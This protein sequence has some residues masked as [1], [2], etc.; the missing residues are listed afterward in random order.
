MVKATRDFETRFTRFHDETIEVNGRFGPINK[1]VTFLWKPGGQRRYQKQQSSYRSKTRRFRAPNPYGLDIIDGSI[2]A[3]GAVDGG[4][5]SN[6]LLPDVVNT[7]FHAW[8]E[9]GLPVTNTAASNKA[10][11][12]FV[13]NVRD[14][15]SASAAVT[16]AEWRQSE[17]MIAL[18]AGQ[19][20]TGIRAAK[21]GDLRA[22][23]RLFKPPKGF[24]PKAKAGANLWLE[25]H[26]GWSPLVNDIDSAIK[27][28]A[29]V[30]PSHKVRGR[31]SASTAMTVR[32]GN[33][34]TYS[35]AKGTIRAFVECGGEVFVSNPNLA[36]AN[37]LGLT[38]P[39]TVAW[40]LVPFSFLVD[41]FL[42][43][44]QFLNSF[45]D[46]L[47]YT[48]NYPYTTTKRV[49]TG[50]HDQH[51]GRYFAIT[52][53]EAVNLNRVL[54]LPTYKLRTVPFEGFSV[55]R[56]ATAISLVIQQFLS[57]KR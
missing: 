37:Q 22:L 18:R 48:V 23:G 47:G 10:L 29:S 19:L 11:S 24:K 4:G 32:S 31:G 15:N 38:N 54:S 56:A 51:D 1:N 25:Y 3:L 35:E 6:G 7:S 5:D 33:Q 44:G 30:P 41:W 12:S 50:S 9:T 2:R 52:R 14:R 16:L 36:L 34:T 55:A 45:T 27:V 46:L 39:A 40:E 43:V 20:L 13:N 57:I 49:A 42:P 53:I 26:F 21:R 8:S 28:L 17:K